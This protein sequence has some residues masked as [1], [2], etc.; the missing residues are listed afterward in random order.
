MTHADVLRNYIG[1]EWIPARTD[2]R[3]AVPN[4]A[5]GEILAHV[6]LSG[7]ADVQ[8][9]VSAARLAFEDWRR[10]AVPRRA[11]IMFKYQQLLVEHWDELARLIT[12]ENG[13][14]F[15]E[16]YGEVQRGIECVEFAAGIPSLMMGSVLP[17]IATGLESA[18]YRYPIAFQFSD[19][20]SL[21]DVSSSHCLRQHVRAETVG[22]YADA[23]E[24]FSRI[25][26]G[27]GPSQRCI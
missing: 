26:G 3:E 8:S 18:M 14:N 5:T 10:V 19:D 16:A 13:K 9:A 15:A 20:G 17:D 11:R 23:G 25:A 6:P 2:G 12:L 21:L 24:S 1:G 4:P 7:A 27:S 22:T